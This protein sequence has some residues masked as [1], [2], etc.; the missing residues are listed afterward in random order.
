LLDVVNQSQL[1]VFHVAS[2]VRQYL[3]AVVFVAAS[4]A[5]NAQDMPWHLGSMNGATPAAPAAINTAGTKPGPHEV[6]V[7]VIDGGVLPN[8]PSLAGRL[9]PGYDM[10]SA[11]NNLKGGRSADFSPDARDAKC[12]ER[13]TSST[14]RTH[15]TEVASLIAGNGRDGVTG[16]NSNAK[17]LP[18]R[19][20]GSCH[21]SRS[22]LL[23]S[24]AWAAGMP[25]AGVPTNP[26][27][28][29]VIN[30]S[31][32]GGKAVCGDDLQ[33]LLD[34][35]AKKNIF[36]VAAVGNTFGKRLAEPANCRG[37]ISVGAVDAENNIEKYSALDPRT[38]IYAPGGGKRMSVDAP[39]RVNKLKVATFDV[40]FKGEESPAS[41]FNGVGTSYAS[42]LVAGFVSLL[43]SHKPDMTPVDFV[44]QLPK[45]SRSVNPSSQCPDCTP[46]G[47]A[48]ISP[49]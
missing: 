40:D 23:D 20:F 4:M 46:R 45:Y 7:A 49:V 28:A 9:L 32:S 22:D 16:V 44:K 25:V 3:I 43:L 41:L 8:H 36:V 34:R 1:L 29:R 48:M 18:I 26:N 15:G 14:Y 42:P 12:G 27:P 37:V 35:M 2:S 38:T 21:M 11:P 10:L 31:F 30:L 13:V 6:V 19:L 24:V 5:V 33:Q 47:L 17:I 39:W